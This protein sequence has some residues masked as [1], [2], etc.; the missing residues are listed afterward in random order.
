MN[1]V[2]PFETN[3]ETVARATVDGQYYWHSLS[4]YRNKYHLLSNTSWVTSL[5]FSGQLTGA[6]GDGYNPTA[7]TVYMIGVG[8]HVFSIVFFLKM[9]AVICVHIKFGS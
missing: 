8:L 9:L 4:Y 1:L 6:L 7:K 5:Y 2:S 3:G